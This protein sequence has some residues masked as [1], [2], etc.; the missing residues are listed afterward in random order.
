MVKQYNLYFMKKRNFILIII[1]IFV[2]ALVAGLGLAFYLS[3]PTINNLPNPK[4]KFWR[5]TLPSNINTNTI[6]I[7]SGEV[8]RNSSLQPLF[9]TTMTHLENDWNIDTNKKFFDQTVINMRYGMSLAE[10]HEGILTFESGLS[11]AEAVNNFSGDILKEILERGHGVGTHVDL[12][13]KE[14]LSNQE[15]TQL[16]KEHVDA[17]SALVGKEN[18]LVCSGVSGASDWYAAAKSGGCKTIDGVVGFAYLS[19]SQDKRPDGWTDAVIIHDKFHYPAPVG[20]DRFYPFWISGSDDFV[21]DS[22]GDILLSSGETMSLAMLAEASG[23]NG[24]L[25]DC[26]ENC[27]LTTEDVTAFV[28]DIKS[29]TASRD[30]YRIAKYNV[31]FPT[32]LFVEKNREV[33]ELFFSEAQVLQSQGLLQWA[34]QKEVYEAKVAEKMMSN[35]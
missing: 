6:T 20:D 5:H 33:L 8:K 25:P 3:R 21:E 2:L 23:R 32:N 19:M 14:K 4:E 11:F 15:A 31:Y 9:L 18:N 12:P 27:P 1:L 13:A 7:N 10:R 28:D 30:V 16:V 34:S 29:L 22:G 35:N 17:V 26:G 24:D